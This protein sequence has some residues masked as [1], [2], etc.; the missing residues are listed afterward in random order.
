[1]VL[2]SKK[3]SLWIMKMVRRSKRRFKLKI[4]P[5]RWKDQVLLRRIIKRR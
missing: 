2:K 5:K 4:V 1:M 3:M